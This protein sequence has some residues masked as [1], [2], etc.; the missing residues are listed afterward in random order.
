MTNPDHIFQ[1]YAI[2]IDP[3]TQQLYWSDIIQN[4]I[5]VTRVDGSSIGVVVSGTDQK[6][7]VIA[8]APNKGYE[9]L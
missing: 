3:F 4:T 7:R 8:L 5:N 1:P 9:F 6:P 2:A